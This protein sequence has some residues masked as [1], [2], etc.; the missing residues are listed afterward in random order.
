M[1]G[2]VFDAFRALDEKLKLDPVVHAQAR[3]VRAAVEETLR[4]ADLLETALLQGSY[5][6]KTM[7]PP[8]NDVDL[9]VVLPARL[10]HLR[11]E[12][13]MAQWAMDQFRKAL[14]DAGAL[15]GVRFDVEKAPAH[16]LQLTVPGLDFTVDLVPAF[17]TEEPDQ[18]WLYIADREKGRWSKRSDVRRLRE[19]VAARNQDCRGV[20]VHQVRQ[21]KHS[22]DLDQD[23]NEL[24]CGLLVESLAYDAITKKAT[25]QEAM[26]SIFT[27]GAQKLNEPYFGLAQDDLT[28]KWTF[29]ERTPVLR[30]FE[31]NRRRAAEAMRLE[32]AG[33]TIGAV[34]VWHEVFGDLLPVPDVSFAERL[35]S[36][37]LVGG[38]ITPE[39][40]LTTV[41]GNVRPNRPWRAANP[42][43]GA[44]AVPSS[45]LV[46]GDAGVSMDALLANPGEV[47][48]RVA[49]GAVVWGA[50]NVIARRMCGGAAVLLELD[51]LPLPEA[52]VE[53]HATERVRLGVTPDRQVVVYPLSARG[54]SWRHRNDFHPK[55]LCLQYPGDDPA[56]LWLWSDGLEPLLT[57][58]R[59][60][61]MCEEVYRRD[62]RWPGEELPHGLPQDGVVWPVA[63]ADMRNAMRR[64]SR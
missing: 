37:S 27:A 46:H 19:R 25:P 22:L 13:G 14:V 42:G 61:L 8:L 57:R 26:L 49:E 33:D 64:W 10:A 31:L 18:G 20:W 11:K 24:V 23:V 50:E 6:R 28:R 58:V 1:T 39:G 21:A 53:G 17:E 44:R 5:G 29:A 2:K 62:N 63:S 15:K 4:A 30:F 36:V 48:E 7:R 55:M 34:R 54:R 9:V 56:L 3:D 52:A 35:K 45:P 47:A 41:P 60:H 38:A 51:L 40:R 59:L 16:A 12:P 32:R 43:A